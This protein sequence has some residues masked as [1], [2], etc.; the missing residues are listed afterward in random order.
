MTRMGEEADRQGREREAA[1]GDKKRAHDARFQAW[2][3]LVSELSPEF[4][5]AAK[6]RLK[7]TSRHWFRPYWACRVPYGKGDSDY[8]FSECVA[9]FADGTWRF[10]KRD[11]NSWGIVPRPAKSGFGRHDYTFVSCSREDVRAAFVSKLAQSTRT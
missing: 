5:A 7:R 2:V 9:V 6:G 3:E 11:T 1:A 8:D 10:A 4:A